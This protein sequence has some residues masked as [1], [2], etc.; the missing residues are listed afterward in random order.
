M[1]RGE[2]GDHCDVITDYPT[3]TPSPQIGGRAG[4]YSSAGDAAVGEVLAPSYAEREGGGGGC[5]GWATSCSPTR[6]VRPSPSFSLLL[7]L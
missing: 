5:S 7:S 4:R 3:H 1:G 6:S 2:G